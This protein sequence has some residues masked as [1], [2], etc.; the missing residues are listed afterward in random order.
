MTIVDCLDSI[1]YILQES[2]V[3]GTNKDMDMSGIPLHSTANP[4]LSLWSHDSNFEEIR[5]TAQ[6]HIDA[7]FFTQLDFDHESSTSRSLA[8]GHSIS[9]ST[10]EAFKNGGHVSL[11]SGPTQE[12]Q[13][14][15]WPQ[16]DFNFLASY[17]HDTLP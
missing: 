2:V 13:H 17:N 15:F 12:S 11:E 4:D 1:D 3:E 6:P 16:N 8:S 14:V 5:N 7:E 10:L 9:N